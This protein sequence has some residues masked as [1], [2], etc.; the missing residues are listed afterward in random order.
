MPPSY[1]NWASTA[2]SSKCPAA[3]ASTSITV[4]Q[5]RKL[6]PDGGRLHIVNQTALC[7]KQRAGLTIASTALEPVRKGD[8]PLRISTGINDF[9]RPGGDCP[10]FAQALRR[11][12]GFSRCHRVSL[13]E[14]DL[15]RDQR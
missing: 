9:A 14:I 12:H 5:S 15:A 2:A 11:C 7:A 4:S 3:S 1:V 13:R 6:S 10:L 8:S